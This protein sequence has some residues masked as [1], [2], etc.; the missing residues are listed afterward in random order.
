MCCHTWNTTANPV[1]PLRQLLEETVSVPCVVCSR[2]PEAMSWVGAQLRCGCKA[3]PPWASLCPTST[4]VC[5]A[6][7]WTSLR[8][9]SCFKITLQKH[10]NLWVTFFFLM[11]DQFSDSGHN[12]M[13]S[14]GMEI[15]ALEQE[16]RERMWRHQHD[17]MKL[18][19][20]W[21]RN[22]QPRQRGTWSRSP[23]WERAPWGL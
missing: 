3:S 4:A 21:T 12:A 7:L 11:P 18:P 6:T 23:M 19:P 5:M 10:L 13:H 14:W 1:T 20:N 9:C 2:S 22:S 16:Q 17:K 8:N 15:A